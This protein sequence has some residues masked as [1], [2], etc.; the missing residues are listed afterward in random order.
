MVFCIDYEV[1][2][3]IDV[4][5]KEYFVVVNSVFREIGSVGSVKDEGWVVFFYC[6]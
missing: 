2:S 6:L 4:V 1:Y 5:L 3:C